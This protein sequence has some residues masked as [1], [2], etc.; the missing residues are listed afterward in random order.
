MAAT[1]LHGCYDALL[2]PSS[3]SCLCHNVPSTIPSLPMSTQDGRWNVSY[4]CLNLAVSAGAH[5]SVPQETVRRASSQPEAP[6]MH[7]FPGNCCPGETSGSNSK[8]TS[9]IHKAL[10]CHG[11]LL[12][13]AGHYQRSWLD[14]NNKHSRRSWAPVNLFG[15]GELKF[16]YQHGIKRSKSIMNKFRQKLG[17]FLS[18]QMHK[19]LL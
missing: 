19:A 13:V 15:G 6:F 2:Y 7:L 3:H 8:L 1:K 9:H 14:R 10:T 11:W 18:L 4:H 5:S 16:K 12:N 17:K